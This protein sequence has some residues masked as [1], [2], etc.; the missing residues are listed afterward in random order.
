VIA[1]PGDLVAHPFAICALVVLAVND[2]LL[3]PAF[4]GMLTGKLSDVAGLILVPFYIGGAAEI[5]AWMAGRSWRISPRGIGI[6]AVATGIGFA[7]V[8]VD[9]GAHLVYEE[10]LG[11]AQWALTLPIGLFLGGPIGPPRPVALV[12]DP[13]DLLALPVLAVVIWSQSRIRPLGRVRTFSRR[14]RGSGRAT[15]RQSRLSH[16]RPAPRPGRKA[17]ATL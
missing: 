14:G 3:K 5:L 6:L 10:T 8:K 16:P 4:P 9:A 11:V 13:S 7:A 12:G 1:R 15:R 17:C 2:H